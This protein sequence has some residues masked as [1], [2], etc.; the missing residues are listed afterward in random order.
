MTEARLGGTEDALLRALE[1]Q[2][3]S[4]DVQRLGSVSAGVFAPGAVK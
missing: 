3:N 4:Q 1:A 2:P